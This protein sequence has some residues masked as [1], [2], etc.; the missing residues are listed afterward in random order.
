MSITAW[1]GVPVMA[2]MAG[3]P[4][5]GLTLVPGEVGPIVLAPPA[6]MRVLLAVM[7]ETPPRT[8]S[9]PGAVP[10]I[11]VLP[12]RSKDSTVGPAKPLTCSTNWPC[13]VT[14]WTTAAPPM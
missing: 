9:E 11:Q 5:N 6:S 12:L 8:R 1:G 14:F 2:G 4:V 10:A 3:W 7:I 13:W